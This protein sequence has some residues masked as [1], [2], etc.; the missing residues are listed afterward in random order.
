MLKYSPF[1]QTA[2]SQGST[3]QPQ[4]QMNILA[5]LAKTEGFEQVAREIVHNIWNI[6]QFIMFR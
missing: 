6:L 4:P 2:T 5:P 1:G 3:T